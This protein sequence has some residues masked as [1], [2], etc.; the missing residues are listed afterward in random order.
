MSPPT[1]LTLPLEIQEEILTHLAWHEHYQAAPIHPEWHKILQKPS[2]RS[3][4]YIPGFY[5]ASQSSENLPGATTNG[6]S[7]PIPKDFEY[8]FPEHGQTVPP[9][10]ADRMRYVP[11]IHRLLERSGLGARYPKD[12]PVEITLIV[13]LHPTNKTW[14]LTG[15]PLLKTDTLSYDPDNTA[16]LKKLSPVASIEFTGNNVGKPKSKRQVGVKT[17]TQKSLKSLSM[18]LAEQHIDLETTSLSDLFDRVHGWLKKDMPWTKQA[19]GIDS[20]EEVLDCSLA[21]NRYSCG[22]SQLVAWLD[23]VSGGDSP[24]SPTLS[25]NKFLKRVLSKVGRGGKVV[26]AS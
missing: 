12:K 22:A 8:I 18:V 21:F 17:P 25:G 2:F 16:V 4:R 6:D 7:T 10:Y 15:N 14:D 19:H 20:W 11:G 23:L 24:T 26:R 9:E 5:K 3:Q 13:A 1:L